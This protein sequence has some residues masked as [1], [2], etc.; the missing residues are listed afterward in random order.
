MHKG[1]HIKPCMYHKSG[2]SYKIGD[3]VAEE[4][5]RITALAKLLALE[6]DLGRVFFHLYSRIN[7]GPM[8]NPLGI[9]LGSRLL[10]SS[11]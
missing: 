1:V 2:S 3:T 4:L 8:W 5:L 7:M 10:P 6:F 11:M 9:C